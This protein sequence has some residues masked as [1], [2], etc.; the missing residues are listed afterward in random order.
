MT[1]LFLPLLF[2][3][4]A[5]AKRGPTP[6]APPAPSSAAAPAVSLRGKPSAPMDEVDDHELR[7]VLAAVAKHH[8]EDES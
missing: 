6:P 8:A 4:A 5:S 2:V 3:L 7:A 1:W